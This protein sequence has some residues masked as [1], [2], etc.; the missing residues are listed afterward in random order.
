MKYQFRLGGAMLC[1]GF[2]TW[3]TAKAD[4]GVFVNLERARLA[5]HEAEVA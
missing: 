3:L 5:G 2:D 1:R 4:F